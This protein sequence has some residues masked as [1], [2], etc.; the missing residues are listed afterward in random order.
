MKKNKNKKKKNNNLYQKNQY[1]KKSIKKI[2]FEK[3]DF[4]FQNYGQSS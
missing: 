2:L 3:W 4:S 1:I